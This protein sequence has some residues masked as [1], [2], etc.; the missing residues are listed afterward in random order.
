MSTIY[1]MILLLLLLFPFGRFWWQGQNN[2][3]HKFENILCK[4]LKVIQ[5]MSKYV[6]LL[7]TTSSVYSENQ[8]FSFPVGCCQ[9]ASDGEPG[10]K[11]DREDLL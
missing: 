7:S 4:L 9:T 6:S 2:E 5:L 3:N 1:K 11:Q 8:Y 10:G